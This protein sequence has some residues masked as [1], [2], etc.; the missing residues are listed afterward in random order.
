MIPPTLSPL[1]CG[2]AGKH[3][4]RPGFPPAT[5]PG[6]S[7]RNQRS[8]GV[9]M[10]LRGGHTFRISQ[11]LEPARPPARV[12]QPL[13]SGCPQKGTE[14][15]MPWIAAPGLLQ[16]VCETRTARGQGLRFSLVSFLFFSFFRKGKQALPRLQPSP[17]LGPS[18]A[19]AHIWS[20][21]RAPARP[22][23]GKPQGLLLPG[24]SSCVVD[25]RG[26]RSQE[27]DGCSYLFRTVGSRRRWAGSDKLEGG[28]GW[29]TVSR[30]L[31]PLPLESKWDS[32]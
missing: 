16:V 31:G 9:H 19:L 15:G 12:V 6:C 26:Q 5:A 23:G 22:C 20:L 27:W 29:S 14:G 25:H 11:S 17:A 13:R 3:S 30:L 18:A 4:P 21:A 24:V 2:F 7:I 28:H 10:D 8:D 1:P 32:L